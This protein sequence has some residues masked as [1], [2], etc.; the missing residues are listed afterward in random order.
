LQFSW[1]GIQKY[2]QQKT[3]HG[4]LRKGVGNPQ[5][6]A[7]KILEV[8]LLYFFVRPSQMICTVLTLA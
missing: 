6:A 3:A 1:F 2:Q 4:D 8:L 5:L 7:K